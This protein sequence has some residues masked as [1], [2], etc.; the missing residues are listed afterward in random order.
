MYLNS[1]GQYLKNCHQEG[2]NRFAF[3]YD[4]FAAYFQPTNLFWINPIFLKKG[5][6]HCQTENSNPKVNEYRV[7]TRCYPERN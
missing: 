6:N 1:Q 3:V 2:L 5:G 7:S 4:S